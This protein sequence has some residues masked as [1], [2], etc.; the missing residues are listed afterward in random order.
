MA[1][2]TARFIVGTGRCGST[3]LSKMMNLHPD[4]A[5]L[6]EFMVSMDIVNRLGQ[7]EISGADFADLLDC[8][9]KAGAG[10]YKRIVNHLRT[11]EIMYLGGADNLPETAEGYK[12]GVF[13][14]ILLIPL[15]Q[16][17]DDPEPV[18]HELIALARA[19]P[20]QLLSDQYRI[21]FEWLC[22]KAGK[23][24][25][26]ERSGGSI[27]CVD[28][29]LELFPEAK[30]L[31]LYRDPLDVAL[32][33]QQHNHFRVMT[34]EMLDLKT[35]DGIRWG[36]LDETDLNNRRPMSE[37]L[38]SVMRH[39]VP[40]EPFLENVRDTSLAGLAAVDKLTDEQYR[41]VSFE[42]IMAQPKE[43]LVDIADFFGLSA[44]EDWLDRA[45]ALLNPDKLAKNPED[46]ALRALADE[47]CGD[48]M[49]RLR[50]LDKHVV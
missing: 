18:F 2:Q 33:M 20:T 47:Y 44:N 35:D 26:I 15:A 1:H 38:A 28:P 13:P 16:L 29:L 9:V 31:Y 6:S 21:I 19:L 11:P 46:P 45:A 14:E 7:R 8:G 3:I 27:F 30:F 41:A 50:A 4:V 17:F 23:T 42:R 43:A 24:I 48:V 39:P 22:E 36:D 40:L 5:V 10:E 32:S 49:R 12:D 34:F 37:R 25:W